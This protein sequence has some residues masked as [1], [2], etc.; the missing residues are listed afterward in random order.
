MPKKL[1][2]GRDFKVVTSLNRIYSLHLLKS[3][4]GNKIAFCIRLFKSSQEDEHFVYYT[5]QF[6]IAG[7]QYK[8][9]SGK[10]RFKSKVVS[11]KLKIAKNNGD[12]YTF[13]LAEGE[14]GMHA[15]RAG[16]H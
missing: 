2:N 5:Y 10:I 6:S 7:D 15:E 1:G 12:V 16:W 9:A 8:S 11:G 3:A 14:N 4:G 13:E